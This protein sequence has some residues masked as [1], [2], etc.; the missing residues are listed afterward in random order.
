MKVHTGFGNFQV[1]KIFILK[2]PCL[3]LSTKFK[4][5]YYKH[6]GPEGNLLDF[7]TRLLKNAKLLLFSGQITGGVHV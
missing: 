7:R 2:N 1:I 3:V 5:F 6:R 4:V